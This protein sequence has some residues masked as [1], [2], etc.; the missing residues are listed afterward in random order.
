MEKVIVVVGPTAVG[1]N[2]LKH[3]TGEKVSGRGD[4]RRLHADLSWLRYWD[5][6]GNSCRNAR[7]PSSSDRYSRQP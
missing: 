7:N 2:G 1:K 5:S 3:R 4:Q 6:Q